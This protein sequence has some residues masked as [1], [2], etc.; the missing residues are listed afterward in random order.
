MRGSY[1]RIN[2]VTP[3][4]LV[5]Y[6]FYLKREGYRPSTIESNAKALKALARVCDLDDSESVKDAIARCNVCD[7]RKETLVCFYRRYAKWKQIEFHAPRYHRIE[8]LPFIPLESEINQPVGGFG[9]KTACFLMLL[10]DTGAR[11]GEAWNLKW[12]DDGLNQ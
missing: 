9:K 6:G 10:K 12:N 5:E 8:K 7:G 1:P 3:W 2:G 4:C 11:A